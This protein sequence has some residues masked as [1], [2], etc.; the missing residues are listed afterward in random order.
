MAFE[1]AGTTLSQHQADTMRIVS[2]VAS[3]I[4]IASGLVAFYLYISMKT[5]VFRHHL[6]L[7][8][9]MFDFG[10]A[11]VLLW[12][13]A[14][15]LAVPSAY[16]N[17][18]FCE[19]VGFFTSAFIEAADIAVL[20]LAIHTALLIFKKH[21]G[22]EGGLYKY[23]YYVYFIN[24]VLPLLLASLA[25][26]HNGEFSY[27]PLITWCYLPIRPFWYRLVLSW[28]PRYI[29][30]ISILSIYIS[31]YIY[32][33]LEYRKVVKAY[34][35][36]QAYIQDSQERSESFFTRLK[37]MFKSQP[38]STS[39]SGKKFAISM[40]SPICQFLS[41]FPGLSHLQPSALFPDQATITSD[42]DRAIHDFQQDTMADFQSRRNMIERQIR[43]IFLYPIAYLFLWIF[44]F[45]AHVLQYK[46]DI[47]HSTVFWISTIAA[48]MQ[49]FN[50][51]V[52][53]LVFCIRERPWVDRQE[54]LFTKRLANKMKRFILRPIHCVSTADKKDTSPERE[55]GEKSQVQNSTES[56]SI[57]VFAS[58][59]ADIERYMDNHRSNVRSSSANSASG[60]DVVTFHNSDSSRDTCTYARGLQIIGEGRHPSHPNVSGAKLPFNDLH[61]ASVSKVA[62]ESDDG[63]SSEGEIDLM[64][65]LR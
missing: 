7:L 1:E 41:N 9:L 26:V 31:I 14:R 8:L 25:F 50:C 38:K 2:V 56:S 4:S 65:F 19:V 45:A 54:V 6:I 22:N 52:D 13:P 17:V 63:S 43:S 47:K 44:P 42:I 12:Y 30:L 58:F 64:Q 21:T 34:K 60:A 53:T 33:K 16:N 39:F 18:N 51:A 11:V 46:S 40:I 37:N 48:F 5:K 20:V 27:S 3:C 23:R 55:P 35:Q 28:V 57:P 32:V 10:K 59:N 36:S 61:K 29:I 49:P 15:V 24:L 62:L